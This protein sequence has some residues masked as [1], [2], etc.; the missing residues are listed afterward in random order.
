MLLAV[1]W[2]WDS[3]TVGCYVS[4]AQSAQQASKHSVLMNFNCTVYNLLFLIHDYINKCRSWPVECTYI[5]DSHTT[6]YSIS[7]VINL[8]ARTHTHIA[9]L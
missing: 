5:V 6:I 1:H 4:A 9:E 2:H 8:S 7:A 3:V